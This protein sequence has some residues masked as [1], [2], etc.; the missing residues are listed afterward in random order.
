MG[1][2]DQ[3]IVDDIRR[4][5]ERL[6]RGELSR[7]EYL[8]HGGFTEYQIYDGG[9]TWESYC[10][11]AGVDTKKVEPVPDEIYFCRLRKAVEDLGR[12][13]KTSERKKFGLNFSKRRYPTLKAFIDEARRQ[14]MVTLPGQV[15]TNSEPLVEDSQLV[16]AAPERQVAEVSAGPKRPVPPIPTETKR[17]KWERTGVH[18]FPY[19]PQ[20]ELGVVALFAILCSRGKI[21]WEILELRGGKGIDATCY[22]HLMGKEIHVELKHRLSRAGWN[23]RVEDLDYVVCWENRWPDF[24]KPVIVL[25]DMVKED[26]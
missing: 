23:H 7:S 26:E 17:T 25:R 21:E 20:D 19:A 2:L 11:A 16:A 12:F 13:P 22:D 1:D 5:A 24:P 10:R 18:G 9:Q 8:Q 3:R 14:G 4:V 6:A 15:S